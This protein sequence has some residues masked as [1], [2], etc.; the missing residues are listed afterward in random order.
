MESSTGQSQSRFLQLP[1]E[2]R[3]RIYEF[4]FDDEIVH[5]IKLQNRLFGLYCPGKPEDPQ[6]PLPHSQAQRIVDPKKLLFAGEFCGLFHHRD[7]SPRGYKVLALP[8]TCRLLCNE[9]LPIL[10]EHSTFSVDS[11]DVLEELC[12]MRP[13]PQP[14]AGGGLLSL[15]SLRLSFPGP[16]NPLDSP[17]VYSISNRGF[18]EVDRCIR[19]LAQQAFRLRD[20]RIAINPSRVW[21]TGKG[22]KEFPLP[23]STTYALG[24]VREL[25]SFALD[26]RQ[27]HFDNGRIELMDRDSIERMHDDRCRQVA[28]VEGALRDFV[29]SPRDFRLSAKGFDILYTKKNFSLWDAIKLSRER[30]DAAE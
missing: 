15:R 4:I 16:W 25:K 17:E 8:L 12:R 2:I 9:T 10:Y 13:N 20:L 3:L 24:Q 18:F 27:F 23:A 28:A 1:A 22:N 26:L 29:Y 30:I 6:C 11:V 14:F 5:L 21:D 19:T 7:F